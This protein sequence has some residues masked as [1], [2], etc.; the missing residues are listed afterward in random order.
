MGGLCSQQT[1]QLWSPSG[2]VSSSN[3]IPLP[4]GC[5]VLHVMPTAGLWQPP[6]AAGNRR[7]PLSDTSRA[8]AR[9]LSGL[10]ILY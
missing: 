7:G 10:L 9:V 4:S 2:S 1:L 8:S 6:A 3:G 5:S